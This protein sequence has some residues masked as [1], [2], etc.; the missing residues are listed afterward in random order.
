RSRQA[1]GR[2][3]SHAPKADERAR[4]S[5]VT[6]SSGPALHGGHRRRV[7]LRR[8]SL[9]RSSRAAPGLRSTAAGPE[10][11][12][13]ERAAA[14]LRSEVAAPEGVGEVLAGN[15]GAEALA[16]Q[17]ETGAHRRSIG[18]VDG[19]A[20]GEV[21]LDVREECLDFALQLVAGVGGEVFL[22][23]TT[24]VRG[25]AVLGDLPLHDE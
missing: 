12:L 11:L 18:D 19:G 13:L 2:R 6:R 9:R 14:R 7:E 1:T 24:Q 17:L 8:T 4:T 21:G 15:G 16:V 23:G 10:N 20:F 3:F 22:Q 25:H 5:A